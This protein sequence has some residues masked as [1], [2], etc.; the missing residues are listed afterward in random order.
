MATVRILWSKSRFGRQ[1][2]VSLFLNTCGQRR[3]FA[4]TDNE[5]NLSMKVKGE[6]VNVQ[7]LAGGIFLRCQQGL[8][9]TLETM[10][11]KSVYNSVKALVLVNRF[12]K[13]APNEVPIGVRK[14][15]RVG[16]VPTF[17]RSGDLQWMR[18]RVIAYEETNRVDVDAELDTKTLKVAGK[19]DVQTL[20]GVILSSWKECCTGDLGGLR[21]AGMGAEA[22]TRA[23]KAAAFSRR[24]LMLQRA[25]LPPFCCQPSMEPAASLFPEPAAPGA[26]PT[27]RSQDTVT[28]LTFEALPRSDRA[29]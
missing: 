14:V 18:L 26:Q 25:G 4:W 2:T 21:V 28:C 22:V 24:T 6:Q 7:K 10:G 29:R 11:S 13:E 19:T 12:A 23:V 27:A 9:T 17:A 20:Q 3:S 15:T 8:Q 16:F 5:T 1:D